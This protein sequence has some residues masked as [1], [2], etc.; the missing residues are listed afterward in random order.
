[1]NISTTASTAQ[2]LIVNMYSTCIVVLSQL[3]ILLTIAE[4]KQFT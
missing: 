2:H 1:V 4:V 3:I